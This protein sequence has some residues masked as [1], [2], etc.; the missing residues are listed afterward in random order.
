MNAGGM[1][2]SRE[3]GM[4]MTSCRFAEFG[5]G[6]VETVQVQVWPPASVDTSERAGDLTASNHGDAMADTTI[7]PGSGGRMRIA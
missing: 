1:G 5:G 4:C 6:G 3:A 7:G 2:S